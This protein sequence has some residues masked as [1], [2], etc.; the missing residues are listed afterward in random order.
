MIR[1]R[2]MYGL[3]GFNKMLASMASQAGELLSRS[4]K[5]REHFKKR[6]E[7]AAYD[8]LIT[9]N[10]DGRPLVVQKE[11][12]KVMTNLME[13]A[14][15][16][17]EDG[18]YSKN[19][20]QKGIN[21]FVMQM[22]FEPKGKAR[23]A[24]ETF[25]ARYGRRPPG[26]LVIGPTQRCNLNCKGCYAKASNKTA[27][28]IPFSVLDRIV[29]EKTELWGSHYTTWV[30]GEPTMYA[31]EGKDILDI[32][33]RHSDN[34]F[35]MYTN[36]LL[37][38]EE[39]ARRM[40][41]L[42]NVVPQV[43]VEGFEKETDDRRGKGVFKKVL[44]AFE[45]MRK[46]GVPFGIAV[47][48]TRHNASMLTSDEFVDFYFHQQG[49]T[50]AWIFQY[51]PVGRDYSLDLMLTPEQRLRLLDRE[52]E[53]LWEHG[54]FYVDFWNS[55]PIGSGCIAAG[56]EEGYLY[57]DWDGRVM[58]CPYYQFSP[59]NIYDIYK[60]GGNLNDAFDQPFFDAIRKWQD[61]YGFAKHY[62]EISNWLRPCP[63][64]DH[65]EQAI[66]DIKQY[67]VVP[68]DQQAEEWL[69]DENLHR[70]L[71]RFDRELAQVMDPVWEK[72]Y[73]RNEPLVP[74]SKIPYSSKWEEDSINK[75]GSAA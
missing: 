7:A 50:L 18:L 11:K 59:V 40:G 67:Q 27:S 52:R 53:L 5:A 65:H 56:R 29:R 60:S 8:Y 55:G 51:M 23:K 9:R 21:L 36:G 3:N 2:T 10:D 44:K 34:M 45:C 63:I 14:F 38:D 54:V 72:I 57:I 66:N 19:V 1:R 31:S 47:T 73:I 46:E 75:L 71:V 43:S 30:G 33:E 37:V 39:M 69:Q 32:A 15:Q 48:P 70:G 26:F 35:L 49:A 22:L 61:E 6:A 4:E 28:T 17:I 25:M 24:Q 12:L 13:T 16:R 20:V 74:D 68:Q 64:R 42:G 62:H 41:E 58:P